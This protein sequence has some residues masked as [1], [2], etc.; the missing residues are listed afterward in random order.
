MNTRTMLMS[1]AM[2]C[3]L[4]LPALAQGAGGAAVRPA[5]DAAMSNPGMAPGMGIPGMDLNAMMGMMQAAGDMAGIGY[6]MGADANRDGSL[7]KAEWDG[8][9]DKMDPNHDGTISK[10]EMDAM[11]QQQM[12]KINQMRTQMMERMQ[13]VRKMQGMDEPAAGDGMGTT[14]PPTPQGEAQ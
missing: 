11:R 13:A 3:T 4:T 12:E 5:P 9:F 14:P 1:T 6:L 2:M 7:T 10:E 8:M